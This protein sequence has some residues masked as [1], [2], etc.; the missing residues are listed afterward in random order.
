MTSRGYRRIVGVLIR[1]Y[2]AGFR[3]RHGAELAA[4]MDELGEDGDRGSVLLDLLRG[5]IRE[6]AQALG[7]GS[8]TIVSML[9]AAPFLMFLTA[10]AFDYEP[11]FAAAMTGSDGVP[12]ALGRALMIG[13]LV[14]LPMAIVINAWPRLVGPRSAQRFAPPTALTTLGLGALAL[15]VLLIGGQLARELRPISAM[16]GI[17]ALL[18]PIVVLVVAL[19]SVTIL[20][21]RAPVVGVARVRPS[22]SPVVLGAN[23]VVGAVLMMTMLLLVVTFAAE[24]TACAVGV[25]NCD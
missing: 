10:V 25:P 19:P 20:L 16:A 6:R 13:W 2:P 23:L 15:P 18:A 9:V 5:A 3:R 11:A 14:S 8:A 1:L 7:S 17:G 21:N 22:Q 24:A 12:N 4:T